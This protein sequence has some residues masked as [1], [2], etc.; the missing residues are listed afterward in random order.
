MSWNGAAGNSG[1]ALPARPGI[2]ETQSRR[3]G[4]PSLP[5]HTLR[6][7]PCS[8]AVRTGRPAASMAEYITTAVSLIQDG[9]LDGMTTCPIS[10]KALH[11]A[12]YTFPGHTEMLA[13]LSG[14]SDPVMMLAGSRLRVTLVTIH[15]PLSGVAAQI[16]SRIG[17]AA[18]PHH[19]PGARDGF[20][21]SD[22]ED[23]GCRTESTWRRAGSFR[24]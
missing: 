8:G 17:P 23:R 2:P 13:H 16:S 18:D 24:R 20:Q 9:L 4:Y 1:S 14:G 21:Y 11:E 12:G 3:T 7:R 6:P 5:F 22:T 15:C 19:P 10:K